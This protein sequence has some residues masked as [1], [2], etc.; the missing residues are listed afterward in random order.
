M[1]FP[2]GGRFLAAVQPTHGWRDYPGLGWRVVARRP[3][4]LALAPAVALQR[5]ILLYGLAAS[6]VAALF[7]WFAA[8]WLAL[9][10]HRLAEA[11]ARQQRE[12][13]AMRCPP[14]AA[15]PRR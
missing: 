5:D 6:A 1:A 2:D 8:A 15:S 4:A 3:A 13:A 12:A 9:P 7:G 14:A 10:L 11:A